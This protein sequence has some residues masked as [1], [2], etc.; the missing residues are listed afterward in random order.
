MQQMIFN[1]KKAAELAGVSTRTLRQWTA[2]GRVKTVANL[3]GAYYH[4]SALQAL[5][6]ATPESAQG[7]AA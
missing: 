6:S 3:P 1:Q 5:G 7:K 4:I 2:D